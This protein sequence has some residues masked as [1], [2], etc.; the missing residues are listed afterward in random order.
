MYIDYYYMMLQLLDNTYS[1]KRC[2]EPRITCISENMVYRVIVL[3]SLLNCINIL[4]RII[5]YYYNIVYNF[6]KL[7]IFLA[8]L[9][10]LNSNIKSSITIS[11]K[12]VRNLGFQLSR[13]LWTR[14]HI[15]EIYCKA[16]KLLRFLQKM[17]GQ[18]KFY[19]SLKSLYCSLVK[20]ILKYGCVL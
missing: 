18:F 17:S 15:Q 16:L 9:I 13:I 4:L 14:L 20:P 6:T 2:S 8:R 11:G 7:C 19:S 3:K 10:A 5:L 12:S 1:M